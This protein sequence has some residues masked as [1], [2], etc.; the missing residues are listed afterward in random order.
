MRPAPGRWFGKP[1]RAGQA[2]RCKVNVFEHMMSAPGH[3]RAAAAVPLFGP[4]DIVPTAALSLSLPE[5]PRVHFYHYNDIPEVILCMAGEGGLIAT[6]QLYLQQGTHGV[7]TFLRQPTGARGQALPDLAHHHPDEG[8]GPAERGLHP[9][10]LQV[11][12]DR[13]PHGSRRLGGP[14]APLLPGARAT[15]ASTPTPP[16]PTTPSRAPAPSAPRAQ[17]RFPT[18]LMGWRR[19]AQY[20]ELAN[21]ARRDMEAAAAGAGAIGGGRW[22][23]NA[24]RRSTC[25]RTPRGAGA[26]TTTIRSAPRAPIRC[27]T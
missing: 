14:G 1:R 2:S 9:A 22:R 12:R 26:R 27:R 17:P 16:T 18:E 21:R 7:T 13:L 8:G 4:G 6:G 5:T 10:L 25:S 3:A 23:S 11:Q 19:Y 20:V 15:C 24:R